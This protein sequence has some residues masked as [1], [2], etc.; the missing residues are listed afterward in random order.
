MSVS[1]LELGVVRY[2]SKADWT[3]GVIAALSD[4][5]EQRYIGHTIEDEYR[6]V[7]VANETR[8]PAGRYEV[9]LRPEGG[10]V[11]P[12]YYAR[13]PEMHQGMLM[14][15]GVPGFTWIYFHMGNSDDHT[16][17]CVIVGEGPPN[18][19]TGWLGNSEEA[20]VRLYKRCLRAYG[21][22]RRVYVTIEDWA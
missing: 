10:S 6:E 20:Y 13:F 8:I 19:E 21:E 12:K 4:P 5:L 2:N 22:A 17:G 16:S 18:Y 14:L 9:V 15:V 3:F 11:N 7:K 1:P